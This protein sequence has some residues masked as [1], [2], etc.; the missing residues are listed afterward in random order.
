MLPLELLFRDIK[1]NDLIASQ[2]SS[3]KSKLLDIAFTSHNF[4]KRKRLVRNLSKAELNALENLTK[5]KNLVIEKL[6]K[7]N[8]V[9]FISKSDY[10]TNV[11]DIWSDSTKFKKLEIDEKK[12]LNFLLNSEKKLKDII[13][14]LYQKEC[15]TKK[16]YDSIY[17][18]GSRPGILYGSAKVHK[19]II[20]NCPSFRPIL[21]AIGTPTY[22][23]AKFLVPIL[24][25][26]TVNEFTV[27]DS[28]LFAEEVANF[29]ANCIMA[30]LDVES[31]FTNILI[32]ETIE[33][34]IT[35]LSS[36]MI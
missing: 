32:D 4:F 20:D 25:P 5:N 22:N 15:L 18:T 2:S 11:K 8:T 19:P 28:F 24:S 3:I 34:C 1:T 31:L 26:L 23:L 17:P 13:K 6:D 12:Q 7:G 9:V 16:E 30:S 21:S 14:P 27:H 29:D 35:D 33:N 10:K 36:N